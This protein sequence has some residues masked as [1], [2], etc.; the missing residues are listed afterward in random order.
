MPLSGG[1]VSRGPAGKNITAR[2]KDCANTVLF[3]S[4]TW[5]LN[6]FGPVVV[7]APEISPRLFMLSPSGN[8]PPTT[9]QVY[10]GTPPAASR[11]VK[12]WLLAIAAGSHVVTMDSGVP[13]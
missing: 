13:P 9:D 2:L 1:G 4:V 7:A 11:G 5:I 6:R 3:A 8:A 10:G 12:Y